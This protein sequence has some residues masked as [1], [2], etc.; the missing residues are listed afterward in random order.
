MDI[1]KWKIF[2]DIPQDMD[3][4]WTH[5]ALWGGMTEGG[6]Q[7]YQIA[8]NFKTAGDILV[9]KGLDQDEGYNLIYPVMFN[10]RHA[11]ELYL[12]ALVKPEKNNH[13]LSA[14][15]TQL[16]QLLAKHNKQIPDWFTNWIN[17]FIEYDSKSTAFR[18]PDVSISPHEEKMVDLPQLKEIMTLI[19]NCFHEL[20]LMNLGNQ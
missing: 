17:E 4:T 11:I 5:I 14:L 15:F 3:E 2:Q 16:K 10:Y 6:Y 12:K 7:I 8:R 1:K 19:E 18:Y 9:D 20:H 13:D